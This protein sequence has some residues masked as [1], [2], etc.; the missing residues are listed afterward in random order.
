MEWNDLAAL[1]EPCSTSSSSQ[2]G[3]RRE[4]DLPIHRVSVSGCGIELDDQASGPHRVRK[5][6]SGGGSSSRPLR[7]Q[8]QGLVSPCHHHGRGFPPQRRVPDQADVAG[9]VAR[10]PDLEARRREHGRFVGQH[11]FRLRPGGGCGEHQGPVPRWPAACQE[12]AF[13]D[14]CRWK[15]QHPRRWSESASGS[16]HLPLATQRRQRSLHEPGGLL[17]QQVLGNAAHHQRPAGGRQRD[18]L[19]CFP[20]QQDRRVG[21]RGRQGEARLRLPVSL[22]SESQQH[23]HPRS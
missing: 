19:L 10:D 3:R 17:L 20:G 11:T 22:E 8:D 15:F 7:H 9:S 6:D 16:G 23:D 12:G 18:H 14:R 2:G 1:R 13:P 21:A 5:E 4:Y